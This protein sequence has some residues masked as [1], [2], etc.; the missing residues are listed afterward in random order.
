MLLQAKSDVEGTIFMNE[1]KAQ[2]EWKDGAIQV[3][4]DVVATGLGIAVTRLRDDMRDGKVTSLCES[5]IDQ[6][7]GRHRLTFFSKS[8]RFRVV[9]DDK[10]HIIQRSTINFDGKPLPASVRRPG[11]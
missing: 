11:G 9:V 2:F 5:G 6:D 10:G 3:D 7:S 4:A 8:R 1:T